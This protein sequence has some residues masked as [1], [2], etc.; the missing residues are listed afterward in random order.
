MQSRWWSCG[1]RLG[2]LAWVWSLALLGAW[3]IPANEGKTRTE[4]LLGE[5]HRCL[6]HDLDPISADKCDRL[7]VH[8][9]PLE[10]QT[11]GLFYC[12]APT[13]FDRKGADNIYYIHVMKVYNDCAFWKCKRRH[14]EGPLD[15]SL[16]LFLQI[17]S[18]MR[19]WRCRQT[20]SA[21]RNHCL[22]LK[23]CPVHR[24]TCAYCW[25]YTDL[26]AY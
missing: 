3:C 2:A 24:V 8:C 6:V 26:E 19:T 16:H 5:W 25:V 7:K 1:I 14:Q 13:L 22:H 21:L 18:P 20:R 17:N 11:V 15:R 4:T 23:Y 12:A 10:L 9:V